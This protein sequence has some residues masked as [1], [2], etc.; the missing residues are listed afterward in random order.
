MPRSAEGNIKF[1]KVWE[2]EKEGQELFDGFLYV[3]VEYS[4][5]LERK[6][7]GEGEIYQETFWAIPEKYRKDD[8]DASEEDVLKTG[9]EAK[10]NVEA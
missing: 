5:V 10:G 3:E 1:R 8:N 2:G 9:A 6:G 7:H 4:A